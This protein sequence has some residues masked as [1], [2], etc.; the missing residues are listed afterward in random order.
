MRNE[1]LFKT[2]FSA[3]YNLYLNKIIRK[4]RTKEELDEVIIWLTG[5]S[6]EELN[7]KQNSNISLEDFFNM[8]VNFNPK[9]YLI[10]GVVCGVRVEELEDGLMKK[11]RYLDKLVDE[12]AKGKSLDK[13]FRI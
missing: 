9:S 4:N 10:K 8:A 12:L 11:I 7:E 2:S 3:I 1:K 6:L 13:V 5:Y